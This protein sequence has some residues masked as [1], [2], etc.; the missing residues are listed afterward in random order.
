MKNG[1]SPGEDHITAEMLKCSMDTC[2][3]YWKNFSRT[4]RTTT[5]LPSEWPHSM[6]VKLFKKGDAMLCN[7]WQGITLLLIP[8]KFLS[9]IILPQIQHHLK[10]YLLDEQHD[11][12]PNCSGM[13]LIFTLQILMKESYKWHNKLYIIFIDFKKAFDSLDCQSLWKLL[14]HYGIPDIIVNLIMVMYEDTTCCAKTAEGNSCKF[15]ILSG[16]KQG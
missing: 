6:L 2:V 1:R 14:C 13:N 15:P 5:K 11:F 12:C 9:H 7:N 8:G 10:E 4:I 3:T 16:V